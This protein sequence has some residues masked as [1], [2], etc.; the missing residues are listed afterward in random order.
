MNS[1]T[2]DKDKTVGQ[3]RRST[4]SRPRPG[5]GVPEAE[6]AKTDPNDSTGGPGKGDRSRRSRGAQSILDAQRSATERWNRWLP[7]TGDLSVQALKRACMALIFDWSNHE[8]SSGDLVT[9]V[10]V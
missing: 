10:A 8:K 7:T 5:T 1:T 9:M 3:P 2:P 4:D 6:G